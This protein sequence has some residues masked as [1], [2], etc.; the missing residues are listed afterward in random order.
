VKQAFSLAE[1]SL[2]G[3][4]VVN[5]MLAG[6]IGLA[7]KQIWALINTL[8]IITHIPLLEIVLPA[9][10]VM[11]IQTLSDISNLKIIP[12]TTIDWFNKQLI[13]I[14]SNASKNNK[15]GLAGKVSYLLLMLIVAVVSL[16]IIVIVVN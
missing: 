14:K 10:L 12:Q 11:A 5:I 7:M 9:N 6:V 8:Q 2:T 16:V 3:S 1:N 4:L 13:G 15:E